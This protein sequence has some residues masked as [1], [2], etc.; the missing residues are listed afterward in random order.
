MSRNT[1]NTTTSTAYIAANTDIYD[2][3]AWAAFNTNANLGRT[4]GVSFSKILT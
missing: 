1:V 2:A 4:L 3:T